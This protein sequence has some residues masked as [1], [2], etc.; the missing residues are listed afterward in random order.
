MSSSAAARL[1]ARE[2]SPG[3]A[4]R[5]GAQ[6]DDSFTSG[7]RA[8]AQSARPPRRSPLRRQRDDG[9]GVVAGSAVWSAGDADNG[10]AR[11]A[12]PGRAEIDGVPP[13]RCPMSCCAAPAAAGPEA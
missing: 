1:S 8:A 12:S 3:G 6:R 13:P 9:P 4:V 7:G 10:G 5:P 11:S 2:R